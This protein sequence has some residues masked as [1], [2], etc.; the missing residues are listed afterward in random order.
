MVQ[1]TSGIAWLIFWTL[2]LYSPSFFWVWGGRGLFSPSEALYAMR[3]PL[4]LLAVVG[5]SQSW[6]GYTR[7]AAGKWRRFVRIGVVAAGVALA[8]SLLRTGDLLVAGQ[9]WNPTQ[10]KSLATLNQMI[11]GVLVLACILVGL[12]LLREFIRIVRRRSSPPRSPGLTV[13]S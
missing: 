8:I 5:I 6:L 11:A 13:P 10:A 4:G 1:I 3:L 2:M 9:N 7:F 12:S